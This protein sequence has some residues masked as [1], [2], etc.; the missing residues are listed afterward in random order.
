LSGALILLGVVALFV[1]LS[2]DWWRTRTRTATPKVRSSALVATYA[3]SGP[4]RSYGS[5][6]EMSE[7]EGPRKPD[8]HEKVLSHR[9]Q[10]FE[11]V[12]GFTPF[13]AITLAEY[14]ADW[15]EAEKL[16]KAG[17]GHEVAFD[18]LT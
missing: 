17:C 16:L 2:Y 9:E 13:Q 6:S 10:M 15:H 14:G 3:T 11:D 8:E 1:G 4:S 18:L 12:L 5:E 7:D